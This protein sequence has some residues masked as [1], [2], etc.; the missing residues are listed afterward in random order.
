MR[1]SRKKIASAGCL[2]LPDFDKLF[3]V[4]CDASGVGIGAVLNQGSHPVAFFS[5][6]LTGAQLR[7]S[8]YETELYALHHEFVLY[9]DHEALKHFRSQATLNHKQ[10]WWV[11]FLEE[12]NFVLKHKSGAQNRVADALSR[13][14][15]CLSMTR[16]KFIGFDMLSELYA[17]DPYFSAIYS[18]AQAKKSDQYIVHDGFLFRR[19]CNTPGVN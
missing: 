19:S 7:Y 6:K 1:R 9:S 12:Y 13:R 11:S 15:H 5:E 10:A 18:S 2:A 3:E 17:S 14:A 16:I 8:T 4:E